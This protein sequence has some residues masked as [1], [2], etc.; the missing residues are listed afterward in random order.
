MK[1]ALTS[2]STPFV[3]GRWDSK[4]VVPEAIEIRASLQPIFVSGLVAWYPDDSVGAF[5]VV[6]SLANRLGVMCAALNSF[7]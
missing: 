1:V 7:K 3:V 5:P 6:Y 2:A 4:C